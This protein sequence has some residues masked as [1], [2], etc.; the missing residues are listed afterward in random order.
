MITFG[1]TGG[2]ASGKS[3]VNKT[4][5]AHGIPMIDADQVARQVVQPETYGLT[6]IVDAFGQEFLQEDGTLDRSKLGNLVFS[7]KEQMDKLNNI[8][9]KLIA[10]ESARQIADLHYMG[11]PIVGYDAALICEI[12]DADKFRPLIVVYCPQDAQIDRLMRRN[13]LTRDQA[14]HRI[15]A[16]MPVEQKK[17]FADFLIDTSGT[18]EQSI[19]QTNIIIQKLEGM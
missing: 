16:Q 12:G 6:A 19:A 13:G 15:N 3:T 1:L 2:I 4:F 10:D 14:V 8:M 7:D 5:Q 18:V 17:K 9:G 11:Y